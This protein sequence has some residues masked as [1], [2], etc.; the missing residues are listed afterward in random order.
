MIVLVH[1]NFVRVSVTCECVTANAEPD[2]VLDAQY[3]F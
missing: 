2:A 3:K 1:N